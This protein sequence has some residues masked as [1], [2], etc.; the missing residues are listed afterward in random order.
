MAALFK[1]RDRRW[2]WIYAIMCGTLIAADSAYL[3]RHLPLSLA[4]DD[5][6]QHLAAIQALIDDPL[7]PSN[8]FL[9]SDQPS[10]LFGP[11]W[12]AVA[13]VCRAFHLTAQTGFVIGASIGIA[14]LAA[15]AWLLGT[16]RANGPAGGFALLG[17]MLGGWL[18]PPY[19]TGYHDVLTLLLSG[20]YPAI[21]AVG[22]S[23]MLWGLSL[24]WLGDLRR[25]RS[26][27]AAIVA[28]T[29]LGFATHPLGMAVGLA[30]VML[31][32]IGQPD[33]D[34]AGRVGLALLIGAGVLL[35]AGWPWFNPLRVAGSATSPEWEVG[36][37]FYNP[38][39]IAATLF[40]AAIGL[41]GLLDRASRPLLILLL[42][43]LAGYA[44]GGSGKFVAGHRLLPWS[45]LVLH[46]GLA[47]LVL[48]W[49][50]STRRPAIFA[51]ALMMGVV[52]VQALFVAQKLAQRDGEFQR[53]GD[54]LAAARALTT[55]GAGRF[56]G[57]PNAAFPIA[58]LGIRPLV[59]PFAEPLVPD[60]RERQRHSDELFDPRLSRSVRLA[61]AQH[62]GVRYLVIDRRFVTP[63]MRRRLEGQAATIHMSG[64]LER[65][66]L[67]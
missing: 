2:G 13:L 46:I 30:G 34:R 44:L 18:T 55:H 27:G 29:A 5:L 10:R 26:L 62:E 61:T 49:V 43:C 23:L 32:A 48:R 4:N 1:P 65:I 38:W 14:S 56:A 66:D 9:I 31:M 7:H 21:V 45:A 37:D 58:A 6:W 42:L 8:P 40:P 53:G 33:A 63:L 35:A 51:Q 50:R 59:T 22:A 3:A 24:R 15:G 57:Y 12:V 47:S 16:A 41:A 19:F 54:L 25:S 60:M 39:W 52:V 64:S 11:L 17:A 28:T 20:G 36:I 67:Y